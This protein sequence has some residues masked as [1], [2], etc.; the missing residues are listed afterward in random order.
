MLSIIAAEVALII[1][2]VFSACV[3]LLHLH[4]LPVLGLLLFLLVYVLVLDVDASLGDFLVVHYVN[5]CAVH[6]FE[7]PF[8]GVDSYSHGLVNTGDLDSVT[9]P[10]CVDQVFVGAQVDCLG[11]LAFRY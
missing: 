9:R 10:D 11:S 7:G 3:D 6:V 8:V 4:V 2:Y 5:V 1:R